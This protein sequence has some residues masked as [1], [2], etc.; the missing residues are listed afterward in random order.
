MWSA[1][2]LPVIPAL[3]QFVAVVFYLV[4]MVCLMIECFKST[5]TIHSYESYLHV[6]APF[7]SHHVFVL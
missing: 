2:L 3:V 7:P 6:S 1:V 5:S 4:T